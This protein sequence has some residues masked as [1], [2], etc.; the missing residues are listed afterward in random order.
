M[1][2]MEMPA[3]WVEWNSP[4][5]PAAASSITAPQTVGNAVRP[6]ASE[7]SFTFGEMTTPAD[8]ANEPKSTASSAI[9]LDPL[10]VNS[11]PVSTAT[12]STPKPTPSALS[13]LILCCPSDHARTRMNIGSLAMSSPAKPDPT[14]CSAQCSDPCPTKKNNAPTMI[15]EIQLARVGRNPR[16]HAHAR[17]IPP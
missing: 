11:A 6:K 4:V 17:R 3:Q 9:R 16:V 7:G 1:D 10:I 12:P 15:P 13:R 8:Q 14:Y 2:F 5:S